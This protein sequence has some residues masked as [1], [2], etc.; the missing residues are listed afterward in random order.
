M[1]YKE[2]IELR[3]LELELDKQYRLAINRIVKYNQS[4]KSPDN[5][6]Y[7]VLIRIKDFYRDSAANI[8]KKM[9]DGI[10]D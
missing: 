2:M 8:S 10:P 6:Q 7:E 5:I 3:A 1:N 9:G 4:G